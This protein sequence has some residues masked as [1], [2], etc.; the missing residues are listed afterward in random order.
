MSQCHL[1]TIMSAL[2]ENNCISATLE[3][4]CQ[5]DLGT[6]LS[7]SLVNNHASI[8]REQRVSLI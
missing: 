7:V 5:S 2:R 1:G 8:T 3:Q 6:V 4:S